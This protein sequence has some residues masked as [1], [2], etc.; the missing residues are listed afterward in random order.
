MKF[1]VGD[2]IKMSKR[3]LE[4]LERDGGHSDW[5]ANTENTGIVTEVN[6]SAL[7]D[8]GKTDPREC[9]YNV[10]VDWEREDDDYRSSGLPDGWIELADMVG[11]NE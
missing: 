9:Y 5:R 6:G 10:M 7:T 3:L 8:V 1:K 11:C 4:V 2:R